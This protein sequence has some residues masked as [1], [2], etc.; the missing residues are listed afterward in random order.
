M[1]DFDVPPL[2][3]KICRG[4]EHCCNRG[5][6]N[7]CGIGEGDCNTDNDCSGVLMCGKNNCMKWRTA[8]GRWD[9]DDDCCEKQCTLEHPCDEGGGHCD[10]DTD[11][12][13]SEHG[14]LKCGNNLCLNTTYF[15]RHIFVRNSETF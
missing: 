5:K 10:T 9:E 15:P 8:G 1:I 2:I 12:K 4:G 11:C 3:D 13:N 6:L 7:L 14:F